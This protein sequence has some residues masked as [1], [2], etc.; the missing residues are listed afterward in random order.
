MADQVNNV[1]EEP[2]NEESSAENQTPAQEAG[3]PSPTA[4]AASKE[5]QQTTGEID[6]GAIL[7]QFEQ[8]Q[9]VFH[10]GELVEGRVVGISDRGVLIDFGYKSEGVAPL[11]EFTDE[12]G[13]LRGNVGDTVE[14]V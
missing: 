10:A 12:T 1:P 4:D 3:T 14:V 8:E 7:E 2:T 13:Q 6:F 11:E 5:D 9:T